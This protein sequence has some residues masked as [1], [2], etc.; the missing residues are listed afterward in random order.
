MPSQ[1]RRPS[2]ER[3]DVR[4]I[5]SFRWVKVIDPS[6][7]VVDEVAADMLPGKRRRKARVLMLAAA[8]HL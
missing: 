5:Q 2:T 8:L 7:A 3:A 6:D 1:C 4:R